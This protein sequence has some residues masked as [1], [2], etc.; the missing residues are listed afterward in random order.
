LLDDTDIAALLTRHVFNMIQQ[1]ADSSTLKLHHTEYDSP[2]AQAVPITR[3]FALTDVDNVF[4]VVKH[5]CLAGDALVREAHKQTVA[6][7]KRDLENDERLQREL[8][9][10]EL[11]TY[12]ELKQLEIEPTD[13]RRYDYPKQA[14]QQFRT[15]F[16]EAWGRVILMTFTKFYPFAKHCAAVQAVL[17]ENEPYI[18][19]ATQMAVT[20]L[21]EGQGLRSALKRLHDRDKDKRIRAGGGSPTKVEK[22]WQ[23]LQAMEGAFEKRRAK[24]YLN[25]RKDP[26]PGDVDKVNRLFTCFRSSAF[27]NGLFMAF[28]SLK[29]KMNLSN[30][31]FITQTDVWLNRLNEKFKK[32]PNVRTTLFDTRDQGSV[33]KVYSPR[34]GA[35]VN[36]KDWPFFR[37]LIFELLSK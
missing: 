34:G 37:Y 25:L 29:D 35:N 1:T 14:E 15:A 16:E 27:Q 10:E 24:L 17:E 5:V 30:P 11:F 19:G 2:H 28:A 13:I 9:V 7:R 8:K 21:T 3:P 6:S 23:T 4:T 32:Y 36:P 31:Q 26:T 22:A 33:R 20:A 18:Q 12:E